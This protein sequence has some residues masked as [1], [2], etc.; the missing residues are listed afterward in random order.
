MRRI[1]DA[2]MQSNIPD[3][4]LATHHHISGIL[5]A[6]DSM[7]L[8]QRLDSCQPEVTSDM[9]W[10]HARSLCCAHRR[11]VIGRFAWISRNTLNI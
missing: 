9:Q 8:V 4:A 10:A 2:A 7:E 11:R 3:S 5:S 6:G 1:L